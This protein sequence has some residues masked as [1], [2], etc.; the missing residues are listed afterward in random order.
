MWNDMVCFDRTSISMFMKGVDASGVHVLTFA[1]Q[2]IALEGYSH[3]KTPKTLYWYN[4]GNI[5]MP[6]IPK[7][8]RERAIGMLEA[9]ASTE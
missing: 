6:R 5:S 2:I 1:M 3:K 7:H 9:G 8:L 4:L